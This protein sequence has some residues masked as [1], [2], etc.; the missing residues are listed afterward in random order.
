MSKIATPVT[1]LHH[2]TCFILTY[3]LTMGWRPLFSFP[4]LLQ[5]SHL[6]PC[7]SQTHRSPTGLEHSAPRHHCTNCQTAS[8]LQTSVR[9]SWITDFKLQPVH[10]P[11]TSPDTFYLILLFLVGEYLS[12]PRCYAIHVFTLVIV[13]CPSPALEC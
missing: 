7:Y 12:P 5:P 8:P 6:P 1:L 2:L 10:S 4:G 3:I 13:Y 9:L 11:S